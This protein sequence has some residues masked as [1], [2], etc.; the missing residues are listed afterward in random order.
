[1]LN[2][3]TLAAAVLIP[4]L[5]GCG[6]MGQADQPGLG[7][8]KNPGE[9]FEVA[10]QGMFFVNGEYYTSQVEKDAS[11]CS[12]LPQPCQFMAGQMYVEYQVPKTV[13]HPY[14]IVMVHGAAQ[15]GTNFISTPDDRPGWAQF[16][17]ANG[18]QVY[19]V[20]QTGRGRSV[21]TTEVYGATRPP[22]DVEG[23]VQNWSVQQEFNL[24]PNAR[25]HTQWPGTGKPGDPVFDQFYASQV[26]LMTDPIKTQ[27]YA[28]K[29]LSALLDKIGPAVVLTHS[30]SGTFGFLVA[31]SRP[32]L[33]K[34]L[35][36]IEGGGT[37]RGFT[38]VGAPRWFDDAPPPAVTWGLVSIP[39]AYSPA[40]T[41]PKEL[42]FVQEPKPVGTSPVRCW[43][44]ASPVRQLP[45]LQRMPH[46]LVVGEASAAASTNHCVSRYLTQ[47]GVQNTWV[48]LGD[49]GIHGNG[50]MMMLEK[51]NLDIA[52]FLANWLVANVENRP[53]TTS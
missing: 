5:T 43:V 6:V 18:Y 9:G 48:N 33:V 27:Q 8:F 15:T 22:F 19:I 36:T 17:L 39:V 29:A 46:L 49:V 32:D 35:I 7:G 20:D 51:N 25:L 23:R 53:K 42:S 26:Q 2:V 3:R 10:R 12:A 1:M 30:Q 45:N 37:P 13:R 28:Q 47:A 34:G 38:A 40:V 41:D 4:L 44:Q 11:S 31:D 21:Y 24:F 52:A 16:F 50:H 14:P